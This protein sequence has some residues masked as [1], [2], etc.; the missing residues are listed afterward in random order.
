MK[1]NVMGFPDAEAMFSRE[2]DLRMAND[3]AIRTHGRKVFHIIDLKDG[4]SH[5]QHLNQV[6]FRT[7]VRQVEPESP[8]PEQL[9]R[10]ELKTPLPTAMENTGN[11]QDSGESNNDSD[12]GKEDNNVDEATESND[13]C[14]KRLEPPLNLQCVF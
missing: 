7:D 4:S 13:E 10:I 2:N 9:E 12:L 6:R 8:K 1:S 5:R 14:G 11:T 3:I